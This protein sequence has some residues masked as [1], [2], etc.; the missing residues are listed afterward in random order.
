MKRNIDKVEMVQTHFFKHVVV[1]F[2]ASLS[3]FLYSLDLIFYFFKLFY[4]V[5]EFDVVE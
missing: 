4:S 3:Y 5:F 1:T 2:L